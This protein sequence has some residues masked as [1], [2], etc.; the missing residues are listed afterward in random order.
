MASWKVGRGH[1]PR[2]GDLRSQCRRKT[3]HSLVE[4]GQSPCRRRETPM[5]RQGSGRRATEL[6]QVLLRDLP[7]LSQ[8]F[9]LYI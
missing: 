6:G 3:R 7:T 4:G 1:L 8:C 5:E 2:R 9:A